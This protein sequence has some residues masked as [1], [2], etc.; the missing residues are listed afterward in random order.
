MPIAKDDLANP[1]LQ[2]LV[3]KA[4]DL[5]ICFENIISRLAPF[6]GY[7]LPPALSGSL[8]EAYATFYN[9][10]IA[11]K[12]RDSNALVDVM[13]MQFV[14]LDAIWQTVKDS[15]DPSVTEPYRES[16]QQNQAMLLV[17]IKRLAGPEQGKKKVVEA[18]RK[19]RKA[20]EQ[21]KQTGDTKPREAAGPHCR[22]RHG[23]PGRPGS[24]ARRLGHLRLR[25]GRSTSPRL[26]RICGP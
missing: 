23:P 1:Q 2:E 7:T 16:I 13:L 11:W 3:G 22:D 5:L 21:K 6:N 26:P 20:R 24:G 4:G 8:A 10:F 9:A 14:E 17:R 19:A 15:T 18:V 25:P 12:A